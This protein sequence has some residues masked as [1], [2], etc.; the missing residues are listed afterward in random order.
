MEEYKF[1]CELGLGGQGWVG[2]YV[3]TRTGIEYAAKINKAKNDYF[4]IIERIFL[5]KNESGKFDRIPRFRRSGEVGTEF[6]YI[7]MELLPDPLDLHIAPLPPGLQKDLAI[8]EV[9]LQMV[10]CI[11][12]MHNMGTLHRDVKPSN[13]MMKNN[14]VYIT[15]FGTTIDWR[16]SETGEHI[17]VCSTQFKGTLNFAGIRA[18]NKT[19]QGRRDDIESIGYCLLF[20][21]SEGTYDWMT[22]V[23]NDRHITMATN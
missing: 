11:E 20:M 14:R 17:A 22:N 3:D 9:G 4:L 13:F 7:L 21:L 16:N 5:R 1:V 15:D 12:Q 18:H 23:N 2:K 19:N 8:R 6:V 10:D